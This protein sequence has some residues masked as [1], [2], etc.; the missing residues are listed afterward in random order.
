M[1]ALSWLPPLLS[2][3]DSLPIINTGCPTLINKIKTTIPKNAQRLS[4]QM[5]LNFFKL[6]ITPAITITISN[7]NIQSIYQTHSWHL[8]LII[9][10]GLVKLCAIK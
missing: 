7:K 10:D 5:I 6:T 9:I 1:P 8:S 2:V 3:Q 4:S